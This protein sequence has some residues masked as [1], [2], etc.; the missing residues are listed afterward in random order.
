MQGGE[1]TLDKM[2]HIISKACTRCGACLEECPTGSIIEGKEQYF[3]DVDTC[4]DH[5][6][7]ANVCPV[8]AISTMRE[9]ATPT[10]TRHGDED[11]DEE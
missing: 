3:I 10:K 11:E 1:R 7:C 4:A 8:D 2:P 6:N 5:G 9:L